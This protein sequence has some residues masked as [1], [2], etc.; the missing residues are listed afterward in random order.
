MVLA[1]RV[2][3]WN[4]DF[5]VNWVDWLCLGI[6]ALTTSITALFL[7]PNLLAQRTFFVHLKFFC[8]KLFLLL[9]APNDY[10]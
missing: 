5:S 7:P 6:N 1:L 9:H 8:L 10:R 3:R 2:A 4:A